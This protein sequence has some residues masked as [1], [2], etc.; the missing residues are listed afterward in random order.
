MLETVLSSDGRDSKDQLNG[1]IEDA[2]CRL[3]KERHVEMPPLEIRNHISRQS[4]SRGQ[5]EVWT[6][7][8]L[9]SFKLTLDMIALFVVDPEG[10]KAFVFTTKLCLESEE[11][12][13]PEGFFHRTR[14]CN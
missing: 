9:E 14:A 10:M 7:H 13:P 12:S 6:Q 4:V 11:K 1:T 3:V 5:P 2:P 8:V